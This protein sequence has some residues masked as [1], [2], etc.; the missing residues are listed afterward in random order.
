MTSVRKLDR[1]GMREIEQQV[2]LQSKKDSNKKKKVSRSV[3]TATCQQEL[4][5]P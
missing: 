2:F 3:T 4:L 1:E 5:G